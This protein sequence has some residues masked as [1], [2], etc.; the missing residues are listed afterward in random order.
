MLEGSA[1]AP[2]A[3]LA[4]LLAWRGFPGEQRPAP[5]QVTCCEC[6]CACPS[7]GPEARGTSE[8]ASPP[9]AEAAAEGAAGCR[10]PVGGEEL[11][12]RDVLHAERGLKAGAGLQDV[13]EGPPKHAK[14]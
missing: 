5:L 9:R 12:V 14:P 7:P 10:P 8:A 3:F 13:E 2:L 4:S 1:W 11:L 6:E